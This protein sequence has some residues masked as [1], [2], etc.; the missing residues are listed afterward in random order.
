MQFYRIKYPDNRTRAGVVDS[1]LER[2]LIQASGEVGIRG[3]VLEHNKEAYVQDSV[4][5]P[6]RYASETALSNGDQMEEEKSQ[7]NRP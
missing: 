4:S 1:D 5:D 6:F 2:L 7:P 3:V